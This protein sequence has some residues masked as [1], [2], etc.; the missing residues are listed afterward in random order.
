MEHPMLRRLLVLSSAA[1][2]LA[3]CGD[4]QAA[5]PGSRDSAE[6][7]LAEIGV[8]M[9]DVDHIEYQV[10]RANEGGIL[11]RWAWAKMKSCDGYIVVRTSG[12]LGRR[13]SEPRAT[14][15]CR[16]PEERPR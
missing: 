1:L 14:G 15:N 8:D 5:G 7:R 12:G 11:Q 6:G 13:G 2:A 9:A 16:L 3:A 4:I 10:E